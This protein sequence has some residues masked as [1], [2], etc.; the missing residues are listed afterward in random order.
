M[1]NYVKVPNLPNYNIK[2]AIIGKKYTNILKDAF[3]ELGIICIELPDNDSIDYRLS[4]HADMS[5]IHLGDNNCLISKYYKNSRIINE[6]LDL[7]LNV[8]YSEELQSEDYPNDS[9]LNACIINDKVICNIKTIDNHLTKFFENKTVVN[10]KQGYSKCSV[11][12]VD[13]KSIITADPGIAKS[14]EVNGLN[15]LFISNDL[16]SLDGF[17]CGFIGGAT[18]KINSNELAFTGMISNT[19]ERNKIE[20]YLVERNVKPR[21]LT[22]KELFDIGGII[23]IS[24]INE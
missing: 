9:I 12:I 10:C 5:L 19:A 7:G 11:C 4:S 1:I 22:N 24:E 20:N 16:V 6:L 21:Y 2:H 8:E 3:K 17:N 15:V 14:A 13:E 18:F 23:A